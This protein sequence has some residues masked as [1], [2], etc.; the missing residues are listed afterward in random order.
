MTGHAV[1][2]HL[3]IDA[4]SLIVIVD[5]RLN[6][7]FGEDGAVDFCGRKPIERLDDRLIGERESLVDRFALYE[8]GCH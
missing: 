4:V 3:L 6:R 5:S 1:N 7:F 2:L 8:L